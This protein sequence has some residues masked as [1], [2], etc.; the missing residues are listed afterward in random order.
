LIEVPSESLVLQ[1]K[2]TEAVRV[3]LHDGRIVDTLEQ[4]LATG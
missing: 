2:G 4:V 1:R 3:N